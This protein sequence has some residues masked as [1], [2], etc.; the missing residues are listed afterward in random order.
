MMG[1]TVRERIVEVLAKSG[2]LHTMEICYRVKSTWH[3]VRRVLLD[4]EHKGLVFSSYRRL[5][6]PLRR[7]VIARVW[8]LTPK[9]YEFYKRIER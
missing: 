8:W 7:N 6:L 9:G 3:Y 4:M 5:E 2:T 1:R